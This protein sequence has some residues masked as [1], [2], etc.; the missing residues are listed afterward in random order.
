[1]SRIALQAPCPCGSGKEYGQCCGQIHHCQLIHFPRG[2]RSNYRTL[3]EGALADLLKYARHFFAS[4]EDSAHIRFL[5]ASQTSSLNRTWTNLFY[6][7]FVLNFRP[8]PDVSPVLDFYMVEH[9]EDLPERRMQVL[10]ALKAS[11]LSI[12]QVSWIK[13]NTVATVDIFTGNEHIIERDF[14][15]IT[16]F[17]EEGTLL[18]TRIINID[19]V[20]IITGKPIMIYAEQRQYI[21][22]EI[23]SAR[24]YEKIGDIE[25]FLREY[26]HITCGLV[27]DILNGVK[28][29]RIKVNSML[30][31]DSERNHL[32][33]QIFHQKHFRLL[34][35][36]AQ[37]LKFSWI[38]GKG[39][40]RR[41]YIGSNSLVLAAEES[42]DLNWARDQIEPLLGQPCESE[43]YCWEEGI[44]FLHADDAEE[45]Q[46]ELMYDCYLEEWLSLPHPELGDLTPLE[47]MQDI[48]GRVLLE[49][50]LND[51]EGREL[52]AR[53]R[54]EYFYPTAVI[55]KKLGM[56]RN[57]VCKE[58]LDPR[59][60]CLKVER[61]RAHQQL[62]PYITAYNWYNDDYA[63]VAIAIF[64]MYGYEKENHWRLGWLLYIWN[65]FTS[66]YYPR[67]SRLSCWIAALE[68]TL[69]I[70][71]GEHSDL[72]LLAETYG[73]SSKLSK[74]AQLMTQHF[75][76][77][78]LNF[79]KEFMCHPEWQ[80]MNQYEM[81]QSYD[82]VAQHMNL[83][84]YTL[85]TGTDLKQMQAR[86][87]FYHPVNQQAHFWKGL[88]QTT[89]EEF[90]HDWFLL[91]FIQESGSTIANLF[92]D[93]Q[94]C[95]FPPYL[96][97]AAWH[98]MVSYINAYRIFP[99]GRK[100]L[101]F[102]DLFTGKQT[103]VYGNF[104]DDVHQDIVPG[105]IGI[106][107][108]LP[109]GDR[110]WVRDPM[111]I[112][113]QDMEAIFKKHLDFLME[114][115]NIKDSS[116]DRYL[117]RRGQYIIQAYIRA[118][119][120][121][122]Q[123]AVKI[124]NQPLQINWQFGY[125]INRVAA[126]KR[127]CESKHF[128]LL[129]RNDQFCSFLW[130]RFTNMKISSNQTY[131]WGYALLVGDILYLAAA[132]GKDLE[133]FKKDIRKAFK[134]DD[135]VVTFRQLY[136]EYGLLKNLQSQ[137]VVDLA[138]FFD[139]QPALSIVLLRQDYF[140]DEAMEWEQGIFLLK[141]GALMMNY[142]EEKKSGQEN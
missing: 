44:P 94:G 108:L 72:N 31:H 81:T 70:C 116:D 5:S 83:F 120:E 100:D 85:R 74:N 61:H 27:L 135:I 114:D 138:E 29:Y 20:S 28:K 37:W 6:E 56:D 97:S 141:L 111:F 87:C 45:L 122:E 10:Q 127:L 42:A 98:V 128:T 75:E 68:H 1:M 117:K 124:I 16:Q 50:L 41:L 33:E 17:I 102:E 35:P 7:W 82:E 26:G 118:V 126:C 46:I 18:L 3:I 55:R 136:A 43:A 14:G 99:S 8:Y 76:R 63:R 91:D 66:I 22:E 142:L 38:V 110:M 64:D 40:F 125:I 96:R 34:D 73:V 30:L 132:P 4:W 15:S 105:M 84:A 47:A 129:Y 60:I 59:A 39:G 137:M 130:T 49:T 139:Q 88:I 78:P 86:T 79:N 121:F 104:G 23:Q 89:Y 2:K 109:M 21:C 123:E 103:L 134:H 53:S 101:I 9:E 48:H 36:E 58:L 115:M 24:I 67:I 113:L 11:Y 112:V 51:L 69:S 32:V 95:R 80:E 106:T 140:K 92:W 77:F 71:R 13:N 90:F 65:E 93:E 62:S 25:C 107:R 119:D 133:A 52:R 57:R 12:Y 131:Q 19:N 54:G